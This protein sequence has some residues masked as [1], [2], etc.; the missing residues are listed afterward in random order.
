M[1]MPS[2]RAGRLLGLLVIP[3][4]LFGTGAAVVGTSWSAFSAK[5]VDPANSWSAGAVTL[6]DDDGGGSAAMFTATGLKP[7]ST[8]SKCIVV[9]YG[10]SLAAA[11]KLYGASYST[12]ND[13]ASNLNLTIVQGSGG[14]FAGGCTG[15]TAAATN[16]SVYSG[17][18]ANF[19]SS[20][21]NYGNGVAADAWTP[22]GAGTRTYQFTYTLSSSTPDSAQGG[23]ANIGF[24]W[25][26][27][28][29]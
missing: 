13:L 2:R 3:A 15:F 8:G 28:N 20:Y 29:S 5:T 16:S 18:L 19:A 26:A 17:T 21:T 6:S 22:S 11:V 10:G 7:G 24:T 9:T 1:H 12:T 23:S 25:E 27:Q 14:S 4:A